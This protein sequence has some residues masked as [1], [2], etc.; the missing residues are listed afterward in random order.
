MA[1]TEKQRE[2]SKRRVE[3]RRR[4]RREKEKREHEERERERLAA[5]KANKGVVQ[6]KP[7]TIFNIVSG[8]VTRERVRRATE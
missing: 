3:E 6:V 7:K 4:K 2:R 5:K 8:R 1:H